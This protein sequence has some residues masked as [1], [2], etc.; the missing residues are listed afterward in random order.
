MS[1]LLDS[2][3]TGSTQATCVNGTPV[4]TDSLWVVMSLRAL[5]RSS[6]TQRFCFKDGDLL[7]SREGTLMGAGRAFEV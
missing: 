2:V 7:L 5:E 1:R 3:H 4:A 6:W